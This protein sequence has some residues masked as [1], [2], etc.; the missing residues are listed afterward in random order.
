LREP[1]LAEARALVE[2]ARANVELAR[3]DLDKTA[4]RAP[5]PGRVLSKSADIGQFVNRGAQLARIYSVESAEIRLPLPAPDLAFVDLP[6][7][8]RGEREAG[9]QPAVR[10]HAELA[11]KRHTW[12]GHIV[13]TEGEIDPRTRMIT[14]VAVVK[15]PYARRKE[16]DQPPLAAGLFVAAEIDGRTV[17]N[18]YSLPRIALRGN[19]TLLVVNEKEELH[20]RPVEVLRM[21][22]TNIVVSAGLKPGER[23]CLSP[24]EAPV[25]G[26]KVRI[27]EAVDAAG[28]SVA[29]G[30]VQ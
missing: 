22:Q 21:D 9:P 14:A 28:R 7:E 30:G 29:Q 2:S 20:S 24:L 3:R 13:R 5:F 26:M 12:K 23:V 11:G 25:D 4:I 16:H 17:T 1:Q 6:F 18:V 27:A 15:D 8:F 19:A 10:L